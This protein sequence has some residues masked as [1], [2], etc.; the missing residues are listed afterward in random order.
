MNG[1]RGFFRT[2]R[3]FLFSS[4]NG[5]FFIF[6]FFLALSGV[7]WLLMTLNETYEKEFK[8]PV[9]VVGVPENVVLTSNEYDTV[10]VTLRDKG[11]V[12]VGY[13][14]GEGLRPVNLSFKTYVKG[15]SGQGSV[16][17]A[18]INRLLYQQLSAS[19]KIVS[20]K[21]EKIEIFY[22]FG[23][24]KKVPVKWMG[25]VAPEHL[26]FIAD[27]DYSPDS[28]VVYASEEKLDSITVAYTEA[29][30]VTNFRDTL[31]MQC[32]LAKSRGVKY[33]P[34]KVNVRF[35]TDVLTEESIDDIPVIGINV[36]EGKVLRT[37]PSKV[38]IRFVT[39]VS[40]FRSINRADFVVEADYFDVADKV[41]DKCKLY[42]RTVPHGVTRASLNVQ[43][44]DYLIEDE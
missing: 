2:L 27:V 41:A 43:Q 17:M 11:L 6:L 34:D 19:T 9:R 10:R 14:Y 22:N 1:R 5:E 36:P 31:T 7:F 4:V 15:G 25:H 38:S 39:G 18:E 12:L 37:F 20:T 33:V 35:M 32:A 21:T 23:L 28:V 24:S 29:L 42:L 3:D 13:E 30:N 44:A 8:V 40:Q 26:Y 16:P